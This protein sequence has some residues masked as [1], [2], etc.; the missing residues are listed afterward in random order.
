MCVSYFILF[1]RFAHKKNIEKFTLSAQD[2][3]YFNFLIFNKQV[4]IIRF[5]TMICTNNMFLLYYV[6]IIDTSLVE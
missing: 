5:P 3:F 2:E 6:Y 4:F 1:I